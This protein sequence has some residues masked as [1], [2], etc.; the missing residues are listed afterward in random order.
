MSEVPFLYAIHNHQPVGNFEHVFEQGFEVCYKPQ[1]EILKKHKTIKAALHHTGSLLEWIESHHPSY[2]DDMAMMAQRGQVE[3]LSGGFYE[4][5]LSSLPTHDAIGQIEMMNEYIKKRFGIRARGMW[6]AERIW[7]GSLPI[8][9]SACGIE[10]TLLDDTHFKYAGMGENEM[11]GYYVTEKGGDTLAIFPIDKNLR[12]SIPFKWPQENIDYFKTLANNDSVDCVTYGDDGE[13]FGMWPDTHDW[14]YGQN[15]LENFYQALEENEDLVK[16][17]HFGD[18]I[19]NHKAR[20]RVY[21]PY[22]S[23]EEM[24]QWALPAKMSGKFQTLIDELSSEGKIDDYRPFLR[25]GMWP[26][27]QTKYDESNRLHKKMIF[28]SQKVR[29]A[30]HKLPNKKYEEAKT[31]LYRGQC[32]CPYWH[33]MFGGLYL[34]YLRHAV[35]SHLI[36]AEKIVTGGDFFMEIFDYDKDGNDEII[37]GGKVISLVIDPDY[38][39]TLMELDYLPADFALTNTL[40]RRYEAYHDKIV[41]HEDSAQDEN[42]PASIHDIVRVKEEGLQNFLVYDKSERRMLQE[43]VIRAGTTFDDY[44]RSQYEEFSDFSSGAYELVKHDSKHALGFVTLRKTGSFVYDDNEQLLCITKE[45]TADTSA[46]TISVEYDIENCGEKKM[47]VDLAIELNMTLLAGMADDRYYKGDGIP[48]GEKIGK[49]GESINA[50]VC[51]MR[52]DWFNFEVKAESSDPCTIWRQPIETVSQSESGFERTYQGSA[53]V[54]VYR[55]ALDSKE[56]RVFNLSIE[57][58]N[59]K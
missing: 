9:T 36:K 7:D 57:I 50:K 13:K 37:I 40:T 35:Y 12:Y 59:T 21:L 10:F 16:T 45:I 41:E 32:N 38:G 27:F 51:A 49:K 3:I 22:A 6:T 26:S 11:F 43:R 2:I 42:A 23:Y 56:K 33:G 14:V 30:K 44:S 19:D 17:T 25:G 4:P 34:N 48:P 18:F 55:L 58:K 8:I 28:V 1:L 31:E 53:M 24:M 15:W 29:E 54:F 52:D 20:G 39:G 5:I 46:G 47:D